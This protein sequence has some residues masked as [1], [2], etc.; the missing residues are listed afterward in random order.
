GDPRAAI[1]F[2][3]P[4]GS[5]ILDTVPPSGNPTTGGIGAYLWSQILRRGQ[6]VVALEG[7]GFLYFNFKFR[8]DGTGVFTGDFE[9]DGGADGV[10]SLYGTF[11]TSDNP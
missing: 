1:D 3:T 9:F 10:F 8:D 5:F 2:T 4:L 6:I 7:Q 11:T